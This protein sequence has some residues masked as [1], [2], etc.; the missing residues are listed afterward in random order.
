MSD[1]LGGIDTLMLS[2]RLS[3]LTERASQESQGVQT[4]PEAELRHFLQRVQTERQPLAA[5]KSAGWE[6]NVTAIDAPYVSH[7]DA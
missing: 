4:G 6:N 3:D 5:V 7:C 1:S 2:R